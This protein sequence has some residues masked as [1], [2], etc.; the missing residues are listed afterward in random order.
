MVRHPWED[1]FWVPQRENRLVAGD[2]GAACQVKCGAV[3][4]ECSEPRAWRHL[5]LTPV[6]F[7]Q[8]TGLPG[9]LSSFYP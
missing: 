2:V 8:V 6:R 4:T 7:L 5:L 1:A 3:R 9:P